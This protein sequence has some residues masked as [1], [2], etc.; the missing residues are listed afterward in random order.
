MLT[1]QTSCSPLAPHPLGF[2]NAKRVVPSPPNDFD[3]MGPQCPAA[4]VVAVV[5]ATDASD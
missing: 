3:D 4:K 5:V 1:I 2:A